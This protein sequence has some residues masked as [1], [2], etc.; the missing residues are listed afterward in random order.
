VLSQ[1]FVL[2]TLNNLPNSKVVQ[3]IVNEGHYLA[4]AL[5]ANKLE[6]ANSW[7]LNRDGKTR[8]QKIVDTSIKL[9]SEV[10]PVLPMKVQKQF[11]MLQKLMFSN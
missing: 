8:K 7:G 2:V 11:R 6:A 9:D 1:H 10:L 5:I 3:S 4:K